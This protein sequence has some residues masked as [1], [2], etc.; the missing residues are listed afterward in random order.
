MSE[1]GNLFL[2][3]IIYSV[4]NSWYFCSTYYMYLKFVP[5]PSPKKNSPLLLFHTLPLFCKAINFLLRL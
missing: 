5:K 3:L 4:E 1:S 2:N